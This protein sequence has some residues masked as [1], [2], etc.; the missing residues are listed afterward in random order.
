MFGYVFLFLFFLCRHSQTLAFPLFQ[1]Q[2]KK[3]HKLVNDVELTTQHAIMEAAADGTLLEQKVS[4]L[5]TTLPLS[6]SLYTYPQ[7]LKTYTLFFFKSVFMSCL[8][9]VGFGTASG[10]RKGRLSCLRLVFRPNPNPNPNPNL[11]L[12]N[13]NP[14]PNPNPP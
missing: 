1:E 14:N 2:R 6:F 9:C 13:P 11:N 8:I 7:H 4:T 5:T 3:Q 10:Q 12:N